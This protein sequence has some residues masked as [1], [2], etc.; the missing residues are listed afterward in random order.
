MSPT[1]T[2]V[3]KLIKEHKSVAEYAEVDDKGEKKFKPTLQPIYVRRNEYLPAAYTV[4]LT[5]TEV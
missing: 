5:P 1:I 4:T 2:V 3:M